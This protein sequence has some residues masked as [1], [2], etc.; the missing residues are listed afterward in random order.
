MG[1]PGET[2]KMQKMRRTQARCGRCEEC[3]KDVGM[4]GE[5]R[6]DADVARTHV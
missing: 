1:M 5:I 4:Q 6:V 2:S 3:R